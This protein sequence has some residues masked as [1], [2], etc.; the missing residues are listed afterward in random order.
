MI[1]AKCR[2]AEVVPEKKIRLTMKIM[3]LLLVVLDPQGIEE[4]FQSIRHLLLTLPQQLLRTHAKEENC[5]ENFGVMRA[6]VRMEYARNHGE[7]K[8]HCI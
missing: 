7:F 4:H 6:V 8:C 5:R 1:A 2:G 3:D